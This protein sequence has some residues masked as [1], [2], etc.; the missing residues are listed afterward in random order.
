MSV[1]LVLEGAIVFYVCQCVSMSDEAGE[2]KG[3]RKEL[4]AKRW[5]EAQLNVGCCLLCNSDI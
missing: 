2:G 4:K 1:L 3:D 5:K